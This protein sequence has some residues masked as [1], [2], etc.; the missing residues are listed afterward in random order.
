[1]VGDPKQSIYSFQGADV[2]VYKA[3]VEEIGKDGKRYS[4]KTNFRSTN[5]IIQGCN[6]LFEP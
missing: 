5:G 3:A 2:N 1:V 6:K 4:L